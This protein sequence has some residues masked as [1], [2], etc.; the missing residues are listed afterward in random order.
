VSNFFRN[1]LVGS[2]TKYIS[3]NFISPFFDINVGVEQGSALSPILSAL[4]LSLVFY[5]LEKRLKI[6]KISISVISFVDNGLFVSQSKS[7]L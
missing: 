3:N 4:Y 2:K 1:Y 5:S 6:L 7:I